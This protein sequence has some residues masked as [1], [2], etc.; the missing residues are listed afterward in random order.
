MIIYDRCLEM[1][2]VLRSFLRATA[3]PQASAY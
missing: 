2:T 3:V 1:L